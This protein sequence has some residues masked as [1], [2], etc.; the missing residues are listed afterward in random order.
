MKKSPSVVKETLKKRGT[1][2]DKNWGGKGE[3]ADVR[4][5]RAWV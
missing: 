3:L 5:A 1:K 2:K 4:Q